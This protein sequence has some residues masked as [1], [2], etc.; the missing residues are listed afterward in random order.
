MVGVLEYTVIKGR[1]IRSVEEIA[2]FCDKST[3]EQM[4]EIGLSQVPTDNERQLLQMIEEACSHIHQRPD[5][6]FV[7]HSLPFIRRNGEVLSCDKTIPVFYLSGLPCA[8]MHKAVEAACKLIDSHEYDT[9]LV[10][11]ADKAYSD[12]ERVFFGTIMGD[13]VVAV[14]LGETVGKHTI[15]SSEISTTVIAPDGE[16][17]SEVAVQQF[18]SVNAALMRAAIQRCMEKAGIAAVDYFVTHTSNRKFWDT[19]AVLMKFPRNKF[20]DDNIVHT[21][22]MNSHDSFLHYFFFCEQ[23]IIHKGEITMLI[24]PGFGG[25]QGCTLIK[26]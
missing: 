3:H 15:L 20:C 22:H 24:N 25:T 5:C 9:V 18:R 13:A 17:S 8:I 6:I 14:L 23:G 7:A 19:M 4:L 26:T 1:H 11:G 10:I 16:N 12:T 2:S 21:G